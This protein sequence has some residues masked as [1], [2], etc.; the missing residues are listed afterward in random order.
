[1]SIDVEITLNRFGFRRVTRNK[2]QVGPVRVSWWRGT[3]KRSI[4]VEVNWKLSPDRGRT[5]E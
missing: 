2:V 1:M 3:G 4:G 5:E